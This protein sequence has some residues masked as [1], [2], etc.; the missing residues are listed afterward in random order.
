[1]KLLVIGESCQDVFVYGKAERL[2]PEAPAP[3]FVPFRETFNPGMAANVVENLKALGASVD[4][5][6]NT[7]H[8][9]KKRYIDEKTNHLMLRIDTGDHEVKPWSVEYGAYANDIKNY[10]AVVVSD[11]SKGFLSPES[12]KE[13]CSKNENVFVDTKKKIGS[14]LSKVKYLKIN[15]KEYLDSKDYLDSDPV[16]WNKTIVTLGK[17]GCMLQDRIFQVSEVPVKDQTGA[18]DTFLAGLVWK[19]VTT[20]NIDAAITFANECATKVVTKRGVCT[21]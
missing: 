13:L 1:M 9:I 4:F 16:L 12:I 21:I 6:T 8:I 3:V 2:A 5:V 17:D 10:D 11:Y 19:Y 7:N 14:Y 15:Q 20:V 18:G